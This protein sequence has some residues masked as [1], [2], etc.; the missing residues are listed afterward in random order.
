MLQLQTIPR[1]ELRRFVRIYAQRETDRTDSVLIEPCPARLEQMLEFQFGNTISCLE[2]SGYRRILTAVTI[3]GAVA[4]PCAISLPGGAI[5]FGIFFHPT[6]L[7]RL[8]KIPMGGIS[9]EAFDA[10]VVVGDLLD[11]LHN[12]L[13]ECHSFAQRVSLV[14]NFLP[15]RAARVCQPTPIQY[16]AAHVLRSMAR[17][18]S[19][20]SRA[21]VG[22]DCGNSNEN[23]GRVRVCRRSCTRE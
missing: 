5:S 7:S 4:Q 18:A 2:A 12:Q 1:Q 16:A 23:S 10:H 13:A 9:L 21:N 11:S 22:W 3:I 19:T 15:Q 20:T 6:G 14:E 17:L 8:F